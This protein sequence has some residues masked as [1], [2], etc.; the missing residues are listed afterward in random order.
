MVPLIQVTQ[1]EDDGTSASSQVED[2]DLILGEGDSAAEVLGKLWQVVLDV[3]SRR[4]VPKLFASGNSD[5]QI[6]RGDLGVSL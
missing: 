3:A 2:F 5:F 6:S 1:R 4:T